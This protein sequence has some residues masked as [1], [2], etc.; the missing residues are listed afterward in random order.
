ME[1]QE[2][3]SVDSTIRKALEESLQDIKENRDRIRKKGNL[4]QDKEET[5]Q[6][7]RT[8]Q[9]V[10]PRRTD[11]KVISNVQLMGPRAT[12]EDKQK[13]EMYAET[14]GWT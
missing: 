13:K 6:P 3:G 14:K 2:Q 10:R 11:I 1:R 8:P 7:Q 12:V 9:G 5:P 4:S